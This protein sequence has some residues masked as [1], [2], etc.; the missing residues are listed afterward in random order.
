[1]SYDLKKKDIDYSR[2][3]PITG[4][5][6]AYYTNY[7]YN[8]IPYYTLSFEGEKTGIARYPNS[9]YI[10]VDEVISTGTPISEWENGIAEGFTIAQDSERLI[11]WSEEKIFIWQYVLWETIML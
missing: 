4:H 2:E 6:T 3:L 9:G 7:D 11:K 8:K 5:S 1:M 10:T